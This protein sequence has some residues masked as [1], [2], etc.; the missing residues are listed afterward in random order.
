MVK[1]ERTLQMQNVNFY[2]K[3]SKNNKFLTHKNV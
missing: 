3:K 1:Y 2:A